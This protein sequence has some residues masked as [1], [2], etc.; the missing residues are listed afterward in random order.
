[1]A[2]G[3]FYVF[4]AFV[5]KGQH[6]FGGK[7]SSEV[8]SNT[9]RRRR[10]EAAIGASEDDGETERLEETQRR[11]KAAY[12]AHIGIVDCDQVRFFEG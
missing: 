12:G 2:A 4:E 6:N 8:E 9:S 1:M 11:F 3:A 5:L 10:K 7:H